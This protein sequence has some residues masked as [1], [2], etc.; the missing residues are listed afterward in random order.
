MGE[1]DLRKRGLPEGSPWETHITRRRLLRSTG[2]GAVGLFAGSTLLAAC[3]GDDEG[4]GGGGGGGGG[5]LDHV[6]VGFAYIGPI[7]DNGWTFT[8]DQGRE[9]VDASLGDKVTTTFVEN[10]PLSAEA[11]TTFEQLASENNLV[12]ANTEYANFLSDV[13]AQHPDVA[14]LEAD[15]H[16]YTDNLYAYYVE[17]AR[18]NYLLGVA[19]GVLS[20][21]G[22]LGYVGAF[23]TATAWND[24]NPMLL[25]ARTINPNATVQA[26]M[27]SSFFDPQKA[28][29]AT[30][31]LID[32]GADFIFSVMDEPSFLQVCED[33]GVWGAS[34]NLDIREFGPNAYVNTYQL[35]WRDFYVE[36]AQKVL[37]GT[38]T[39][40]SGVRLLPLSLGEWGDNVP[41]E[42]KDAVAAADAELAAA[43][44][45]Y[46]GPLVDDQGSERVAAGET[47]TPEQAYAIDW[48]VE[49]VT[50]V[51]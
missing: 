47:L 7:T 22:K 20:A 23:P 33:R 49:G 43:P 29:Q 26:V 10:V 25:G 48:G 28:T 41:Q 17:H 36:Q 8:H 21:T 27:I 30:S 18:P 32:G 5:A 3:G 2:I 16:T 35:D 37:D 1:R 4:G 38:W 31:A 13:A 12:I 42:V 50:G 15:G 6:N 11:G 39:S 45:P 19:G 44:T 34:W 9:A 46:I 24:V 51:V 40:Q 14:F